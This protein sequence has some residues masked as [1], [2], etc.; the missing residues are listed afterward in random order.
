MPLEIKLMIDPTAGEVT[1]WTVGVL[2]MVTVV[3]I[4]PDA[5]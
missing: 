3:E 4:R 5:R 1:S 2:S